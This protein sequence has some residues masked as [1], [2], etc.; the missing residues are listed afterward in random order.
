MILTKSAAEGIGDFPHGSVGLDRIKDCRH[1]IAVGARG[2]LHRIKGCFDAGGVAPGAQGHKAL[3]LCPL[4]FRID[5]QERRDR[6]RLLDEAIDA[7]H[8]PVAAL[9]GLLVFVG[10][11][12]NLALRVTRFDG[13]HHSTHGIDF[14][15]YS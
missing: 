7:D 3:Y 14:A 15:R 12:L 11:L 9:D 1:Q 8:Y 6:A 4:D 13:P 10:R 5:A 2:L